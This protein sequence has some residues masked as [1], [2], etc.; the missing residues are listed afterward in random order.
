MTERLTL[1]L[2]CIGSYFREM[3]VREHSYCAY[4]ACLPAEELD[5]QV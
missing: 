3:V 5:R 2:Q 1:S 4:R